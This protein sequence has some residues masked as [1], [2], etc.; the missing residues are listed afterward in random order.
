MSHVPSKA[1]KR[2]QIKKLRIILAD[3]H[4]IL[5]EG[6]RAL[7]DSQPDMEVAD[8]AADGVEAIEKARKI[9]P[10]V[11]IMDIGMPKMDGA[12]ATEFLKRELPQIK[13]LALTVQEDTGY[14][15]QMLKANASG[16]VLKRAAADE[17]INAIRIV[18]AGG[19]YLDPELTTRFVANHFGPQQVTA[20]EKHPPLSK[21]EQDV[22]RLIAWGYTNKEIAATLKISVKTV[23]TYKARL[24]VKL[25]L[26]S[27]VDIVRYA[28]RHGWLDEK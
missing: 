2:S 15:S 25:D 6:L 21:R 19:H 14:L 3:D 22:M 23:E 20:E 28:L 16:Y 10:D 11:V 7:I 13:V 5:R 8:E 27:R 18:A 12:Q 4:R 24:M 9:L 1:G 17:L 26:R